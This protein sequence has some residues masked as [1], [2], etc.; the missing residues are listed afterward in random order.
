MS[1][2]PH[3]LARPV[4]Y[5]LV[6]AVLIGFILAAAFLFHEVTR[7]PRIIRVHFPEIA[8]LGEGDPVVQG[9]VPVGKVVSIRLPPPHS[10]S[11]DAMVEIELFHHRPLAADARFLNFSHSLMGARKV[12][13]VPGISPLPLDESRFRY[14]GGSTNRWAGWCRELDPIDFERREWVADSGWPFGAEELD[15]YYARARIVCDVSD[16]T[17]EQHRAILS[18]SERIRT[19]EFRLS[20]PT[21][22]G[23]RYRDDIARASNIQA[24]LNA[25]AV[26]FHT[27]DSHRRVKRVTFRTLDGRTLTVASRLYILATGGIENARLLL[28]S[29]TDGRTAIGNNHDLVGRYYMDHP[30]LFSGVFDPSESCPSL[31]YYSTRHIPNPAV[32]GPVTAG[33]NLDERV[34]RREG[35][36]SAVVRLVPRPAYTTEP[37]WETK[38]VASA[39]RITATVVCGKIP[40]DA[41]KHLMQAA[42]GAASAAVMLAKAGLHAMRPNT[43]LALRSFAEPCPN[44]ESRVT[45]SDRRNA[46]GERAAH[47]RWITGEPEKRSVIRLHEILDEEIRNAGYGTLSNALESETSPWPPSQF[48]ASHHMGTTRMHDSPLKGVVDRNCR[49]HDVENL[50]VAGSSVFPTCGYAN[51]TLTIV[52]LALR[53][54]DRIKR[55]SGC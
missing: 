2:A 33:F 38:A 49:V 32:E 36:L 35:L 6:L 37:G 20:P 34:L 43:R 9:G 1:P 8:T 24:I 21:R 45:L 26:T 14:F 29:S 54:A 28:A 55:M 30:A 7:S 27:S 19:S 3:P 4:G 23:E 22:F 39:R 51:P 46:L 47:V 16:T 17:N 5:V 40:R 25:N 11:H 48:G 44:P 12:W 10:P 42:T 52:A 31:A 13:I 41:G 15:P 53:L 50:F 18:S